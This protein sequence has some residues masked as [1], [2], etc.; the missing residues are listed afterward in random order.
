MP[1]SFGVSCSSL[2][3]LNCF[4]STSIIKFVK[5][6]LEEKLIGGTTMSDSI[7]TKLIQKFVLHSHQSKLEL[8]DAW[9]FLNCVLDES[10]TTLEIPN[11]HQPHLG[12]DAKVFEA[13]SLQS[14]LLTSLTVNFQITGKGTSLV[15]QS[16]L[17]KCLISLQ[18]LTSLS[19][20]IGTNSSAISNHSYI[21]LLSHLGNCCPQL[22]DLFLLR[23]LEEEEE[24]E[25]HILALF[26]GQR[27]S[28]IPSAAKQKMW[29]NDWSNM[30]SSNSKGTSFSNLLFSCNTIS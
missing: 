8:P 1:F 24:E 4:T 6:R 23:E 15:V 10:C 9:A 21:S 13:V 11:Q 16:A 7:R 30:Q 18:H 26:L 19:L 20:N 25:E 28:L 29:G 12:T 5:D 17:E 3:S 22:A 2:I 27:A 14:P